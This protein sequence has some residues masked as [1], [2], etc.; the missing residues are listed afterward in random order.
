MIANVVDGEEVGIGVV[1]VDD[2]NGNG[3]RYGEREDRGEG[4]VREECSAASS[5]DDL[6]V[7]GIVSCGIVP[8]RALGIHSLAVAGVF[9]R[10]VNLSNCVSLNAAICGDPGGSKEN[11]ITSKRLE[12]K[13]L[14]SW[15]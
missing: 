12:T 14:I 11:V 6:V 5:K 7:Q 15:E 10:G 4:K 8:I 1:E 13:S 2:P 9:G 3:R